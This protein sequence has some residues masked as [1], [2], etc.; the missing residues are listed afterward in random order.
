MVN[1]QRGDPAGRRLAR[2]RAEKLAEAGQVARL[3][4]VLVKRAGHDS[5]SVRK[6][7]KDLAVDEQVQLMKAHGHIEPRTRFK[8]KL[9]GQPLLDTRLRSLL[10]IDESGKSTPEPRV[11]KHPPFFA[12]GAVAMNEEDVDYYCAAA[13]KIKLEFFGRTDF[14]FHEPAMRNRLDRY[15]FGGNVNRQLEFDQAIDRLIRETNFVAFGVGI[16]KDAYRKEF[17]EPGVDPYLPTD[18]YALAIQL[19]LE[20]Y[21]DSLA[22]DPDPRFGRVTFESQ[23]PREDAAHQLEYAR[24][25]LDGTQWVPESAFRNWLE[26]GLQFATKGKSHPTELADMMSRDLF[27]WV[28]GDCDVTP[29]RWELFSDKIYCRGDGGRGKFGVKVFPATGIQSRIDAHRIRCGAIVR[30]K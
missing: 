9:S 20:R 24:V 15:Y 5:A 11:T 19:L 29:K 1:Q 22:E 16:R 7:I 21:I 17:V 12:L 27:E 13:D 30:K 3:L 8:K 23:G 10:F 28:R 26:A 6:I 2:R 18:I 25:L 4:E 14:S